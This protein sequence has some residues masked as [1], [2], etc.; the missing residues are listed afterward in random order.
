MQIYAK[1]EG[2]TGFGHPFIKNVINF[3]ILNEF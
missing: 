2:V 1:K 3:L